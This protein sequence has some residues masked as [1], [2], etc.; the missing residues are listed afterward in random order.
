[1]AVISPSRPWATRKACAKSALWQRGT[2][3]AVDTRLS[4]RGITDLQFYNVSTHMAAMALP[5]F[6]RNA[7]L[8]TGARTR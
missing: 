7:V 1:M 4:T 8:Q 3:A 5:N 6:V 2:A